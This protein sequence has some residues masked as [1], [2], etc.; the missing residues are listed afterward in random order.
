MFT[1]YTFLAAI[2]ALCYALVLALLAYA[3]RSGKV[4][5]DTDQASLGTA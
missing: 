3:K 4:V 1:G 5:L 2:V